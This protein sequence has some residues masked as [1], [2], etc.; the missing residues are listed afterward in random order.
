MFVRLEADKEKNMKKTLTCEH[1]N[2]RTI[3]LSHLC[4]DIKLYKE[5]QSNKMGFSKSIMHQQSIYLEC[6]KLN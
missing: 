5:Q 4:D 2:L 3:T 6:F 1:A